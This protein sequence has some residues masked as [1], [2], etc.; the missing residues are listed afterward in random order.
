[1]SIRYIVENF[2][3]K[4][5]GKKMPRENF[6]FIRYEDLASRPEKTLKQIS[7]WLNIPYQ[8]DIVFSFRS[9]ENHGVSGNAFRFQNKKI[10][11][12]EKWKTQL[13]PFN[14]IVI[15]FLTYFWARRYGYFK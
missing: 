1:M 6:L 7:Q 9:K 11:L 3:I 12:D 14:K 15:I 5:I 2:L 8:K 13:S 4:F 10:I